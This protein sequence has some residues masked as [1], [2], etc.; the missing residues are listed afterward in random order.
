MT[1]KN[2]RQW[3]HY[4]KEVV[5]TGNYD[6]LAGGRSRVDTSC[7]IPLGP[8]RSD[9]ARDPD[10]ATELDHKPVL[11]GRARYATAR[12]GEA[13]SALLQAW[14]SGRR[15]HA[16]LVTGAGAERLDDPHPRVARN[17]RQRRLDRLVAVRRVDVGVAQTAGLDPDEHLAV[18]RLGPGDIVDGERLG[19]VIND[20]G[21]H[22]G[23]PF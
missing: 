23:L 19:E 20:G 22:G 7:D 2:L 5:I 6:Y 11:G 4:C 12:V 18:T 8:R 16:D 13:R 15:A 14:R 9:R 1:A 21:F 17:Q 10:Q 3:H